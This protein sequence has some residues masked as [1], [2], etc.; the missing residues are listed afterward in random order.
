MRYN[1][2]VKQRKE[3]KRMSTA[4]KDR[5]DR[6]DIKQLIEL[7]K[8]LPEN[9]QNFINGYVQGVCETLSDKNKSA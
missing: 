6:A 9:K 1:I 8:R 5:T 3:V 7:I 2:V 4:T